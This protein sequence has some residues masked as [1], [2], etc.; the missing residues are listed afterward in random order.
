MSPAH[1]GR[2]MAYYRVSTDRQGRS[3]LGLEAQR[4]AVKDR[5]DGGSWQLVAEYTEVESG[6]RAHRPELEKA[7]QRGSRN[8]RRNSA[9]TCN[10]VRM[11]PRAVASRRGLERA[12]VMARN[13]QA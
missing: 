13:F 4:Q 12:F 9:V 6:R 1:R 11:P 5:L 3:G 2:F 8:T 10:G 7:Q